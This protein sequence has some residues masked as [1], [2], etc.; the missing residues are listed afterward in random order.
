MVAER[1]P[2]TTEAWRILSK[3]LDDAMNRAV[4]E[5]IRTETTH[6]R[7][8]VLRGRIEQINDL[9]RLGEPHRLD[10]SGPTDGSG[11]PMDRVGDF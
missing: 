7:S 2:Q 9:R 11:F 1:I 10:Q 5:L 8:N 6:D 3:A 4:A